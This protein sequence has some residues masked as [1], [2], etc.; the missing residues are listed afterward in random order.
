MLQQKLSG[1]KPAQTLKISKSFINNNYPESRSIVERE[2]ERESRPLFKLI[3]FIMVAICMN[4]YG[5]AQNTISIKLYLQ[6]IDTNL[7]SNS[8]ILN[9]V[10][11]NAQVSTVSK[12]FPTSKKNTLQNT[13]TITCNCD[14]GF[15]KSKIDSLQLPN[16]ALTE[17]VP[18]CTSLYTP[19]DYNSWVANSWTNYSL[20]LINA[21]GAWDITHGDP[22]I[23]IAI[24]DT[25]L[26]DN[27]EDLSGQFSAIHGVYPVNG[28]LPSHGTR[29]SSCVA[30]KTDNNIGWAGIGFNCKIDF[31]KAGLGDYSNMLIASQ[32]GDKVINCSWTSFN[33]SVSTIQ[34]VIDEIYENG[35]TLVISAGNDAVNSCYFPASYNH[36]ISVTS[37]GSCDNHANITN[38]CSIPVSTDPCH[39]YGPCVDICAPGYGVVTAWP[40]N[41]L[42][43]GYLYGPDWGTSFASPIVAGTCGLIYSLN[44][45]FTPD[46]VEFLLKSTAVNIENLPINAL[47]AGGLGAGRLNASAALHLANDWLNVP[48]IVTA[49]NIINISHPRHFGKD[50]TIKN[51]ATLIISHKVTFGKEVKIIV[52]KG[53]KLII[54]N[55]TL[56]TSCTDYLWAG[57]QVFG[58]PTSK[59]SMYTGQINQHPNLTHIIWDANNNL[60]PNATI[61]AASIPDFGLVVCKNGA[62][63]ENAHQA[64]VTCAFTVSP[65]AE[66]LNR[67]GGI[68][69]IEGA[70]F[71]NNW[72]SIMIHGTKNWPHQD[73][74]INSTFV[75]TQA[76]LNNGQDFDKMIAAWGV[77]NIDIDGCTFENKVIAATNTK[78]YK[79]QAIV[80]IDAEV[81][82]V[83]ST[84]TNLDRGIRLEAGPLFGGMIKVSG[85]TFTNV[86]RGVLLRGL[87][88]NS[89]KVTLNTFDVAEPTT[90]WLTKWDAQWN[91]M[92]AAFPATANNG[93]GLYIE[94]CNH[95]QVQG[96]TFGSTQGNHVFNKFGS[97][98]WHTDANP[99][100]IDF[101]T[102][103]TGIGVGTMSSKNNSQLQYLCNDYSTLGSAWNIYVGYNG[104][105]RK[106]QGYCIGLTKQPAANQFS[107]CSVNTDD[108]QGNL[109]YAPIHAENYAA[110]IIFKYHHNTDLP[111]VCYDNITLNNCFTNY[112][113]SVDCPSPTLTTGGWLK[114]TDGNTDADE[115]IDH[116]GTLATGITNKQEEVNENT[117]SESLPAELNQLKYERQ[118]L[119]NDVVELLQANNDNNRLH[120]L[121][122]TENTF[123]ARLANAKL[124]VSE[125][126]YPDAQAVLDETEATTEEEADLKTLLGIGINLYSSDTTSWPDID[127]TNKAVLKEMA[128]KYTTAGKQAQAV[129]YLTDGIEFGERLEEVLPINEEGQTEGRLAKPNQK[130][131]S[132]YNLTD[133]VKVYPNPSDGKITVESSA[134]TKIET[135]EIYDYIGRKII[136]IN[137]NGESKTNLNV[138]SLKNGVYLL[139]LK[140]KKQGNYFQKLVITK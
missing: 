95:Y 123:E 22:N 99:N 47:Y 130:I 75:Q 124:Y 43:N 6:V 66:D 127:S 27:H 73:K 113:Q 58:N 92:D 74:I 77:R 133:A 129:L 34:S 9:T 140:T 131:N 44:P 126:E 68:V 112:I 138:N 59:I 7:F 13:Y 78:D 46:E 103:N 111:P 15:L 122:E 100:A 14:A 83:S 57:I 2:R 119:Y 104:N 137:T 63:I 135:I 69:A 45:C 53:G 128:L 102:Y 134:T 64:I 106:D 94:N 86:W 89:N 21:K 26:D 62:V 105:I 116:L 32:N 29:V 93:Y 65:W 120:T 28:Q 39:T 79:G 88:G 30:M 55:A 72:K 12:S 60:L 107:V 48:L 114:I 31:W 98:V 132:K 87:T 97:Y 70:T 40:N 25:D 10:F 50:I 90:A 136:S 17:V 81:R 117:D 37:V 101:N 36:V 41:E 139:K 16:V 52:Q 82:I 20:E 118:M 91:P 35:T 71:N 96:N 11:L 84:F 42:N 3:L 109:G 33:F 108:Q 61:Q 5:I 19:N 56:T 67:A 38:S 80:A 110:T 23:K 121:Y 54:D 85:N 4:K 8:T 76:K 115:M 49:G 125:R 1:S 24:F 51:N 18:I